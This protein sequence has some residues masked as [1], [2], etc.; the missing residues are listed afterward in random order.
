MPCDLCG[1]NFNVLN[2]RK[3][4]LLTNLREH[5]VVLIR[6]IDEARH[7]C[8][9]CY[10]FRYLVVCSRCSQTFELRNNRIED[11][12]N[13][14]EIK[15]ML[16]P[17]SP[18]YSTTW[19]N[20]CLNCYEHCLNEIHDVKHRLNTWAGSVRSDYIREFRTIRTLGRVGYEKKSCVEPGQVE[21]YLKLYTAQLGG[22][23]FVKFYFEKHEKVHSERV[24]AGYNEDNKPYYGIQRSIEHWFTGYATA[25]I[26]EP[27][28][29]KRPTTS[30]QTDFS[31]PKPQDIRL[32]VLDGMNICCWSSYDE[33]LPD[34]AIL[35]TLCNALAEDGLPFF[36]FF[37]A[38]TPYLL[39]ETAGQDAAEAYTEMFH[40]G[41]SSQFVEV[42]GRARADEFVLQKANS[43]NGHIIS[44]DQF[45][46]YKSQYPWLSHGHRLVKGVVAD[47]HVM[48]PDIQLDRRIQRDLSHAM[49]SLQRTLKA[50]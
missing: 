35:L 14:A 18:F 44:N 43:D 37:D 2:D 25:V 42:P 3:Q 5:N 49:T 13:N 26:A 48:I 17:Y 24:V 19:K 9:S 46:Q 40:G 23:G 27:S 36:C 6:P 38:N 33:Q 8:P 47:G 28:Q 16:Y 45:R 32:A 10:D 30:Y 22:N 29:A 15:S 50:A 39:H 34:L 21:N 12:N 7:I 20:L 4:A 41:L 1:N 31:T 11:Y